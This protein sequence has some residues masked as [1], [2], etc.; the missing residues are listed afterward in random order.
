MKPTMGDEADEQHPTRLAG[1][2]EP[3]HCD[4][5]TRQERPKGIDDVEQAED[6]GLARE[7]AQRQGDEEVDEEVVRRVVNQTSRRSAITL[8][9]RS[10][11]LAYGA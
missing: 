9:H 7:D 2:V 10:G 5:E 6:R 1:V 8:D 4:C 3:S 11:S